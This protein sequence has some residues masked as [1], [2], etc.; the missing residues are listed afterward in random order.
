MPS[1]S[2][3]PADTAPNDNVNINK[4]LVS[5][6][7]NC[8]VSPAISHY[9]AK[10][11]VNL[12]LLVK[13][14]WIMALSKSTICRQAGAKL[15]QTFRASKLWSYRVASPDNTAQNRS[16]FLRQQESGIPEDKGEYCQQGRP[17]KQAC[18]SAG[19]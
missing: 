2:P 5:I 7:L 3:A 6:A 11:A 1:V 15:L 13:L 17:Y 4:L 12:I 8:M 10:K 14:H 16:F 9:P 19:S 18:G